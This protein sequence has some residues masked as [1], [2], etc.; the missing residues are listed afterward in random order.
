MLSEKTISTL[1]AIRKVAEGLKDEEVS[2]HRWI[3]PTKKGCGTIACVFGHFCLSEEGKKL[4]LGISDVAEA[5][6]LKAEGS[7]AVPFTSWDALER[8]TGLSPRDAADIFTQEVGDLDNEMTIHGGFPFTSPRTR[9]IARINYFLQS[10]S[11]HES[12]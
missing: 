12:N 2:L 8:V 10:R 9:V 5:P 7:P 1:Q 4:G 6:T 3:S 11:V